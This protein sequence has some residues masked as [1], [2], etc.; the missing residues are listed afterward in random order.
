MSATV[1]ARVPRRAQTGSDAQSQADRGGSVHDRTGLF[2]AAQ[3]IKTS[4]F[5]N[6]PGRRNSAAQV[7][8][9]PYGW[10]RRVAT[11]RL[12]SETSD[13]RGGFG[14]LAQQ[15][16]ITPFA[17]RERSE[18]VKGASSKKW[19]SHFFDSL[20]RRNSAAY[21]CPVSFFTANS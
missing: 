14:S 4:R 19:R 2:F 6:S 3:A 9:K 1:P 17:A 21:V 12:V 10:C 20:G 5:F 8:K 11:L 16:F 13:M 7:V 18:Q 15:G